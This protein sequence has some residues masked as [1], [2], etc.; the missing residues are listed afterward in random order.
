METV[1]M[2]DG[3]Y[4]K[5]FEVPIIKLD[6]FSYNCTEDNVIAEY[7]FTLVLNGREINIFLCTPSK[8]EELVIGFL[9]SKGHIRKIEDIISLEIDKKNRVSNVNIKQVYD[10][11]DMEDF[12]LNELNSLKYN[13][14][15]SNTSIYVDT[16]Y[17]IMKVN[18]N[19]SRLFKETGGTHSVAIFE[20]NKEIVVCED[21]ARHNAMD[22]AIGHCILKSIPLDNKAI[23]VSGRISFDMLSKV[24]RA[25]IPIVISKSAPTNLS[26]ELAKKS[27][28]TLIGF[29]RGKR[30][31]IYTHSYRIKV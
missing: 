15:E 11:D 28:I 10:N 8:L 30:M 6:E 12:M 18:L 22:K 19:Y 25:E 17:E 31:S 7:P 3:I 13:Y 2:N 23:V 29:V 9:L 14:I 27:N 16:I 1:D 21:V 24:A 26:I 20:N 4:G 5:T